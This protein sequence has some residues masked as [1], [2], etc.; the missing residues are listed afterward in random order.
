MVTVTPAP[1]ATAARR[2]TFRSRLEAQRADCLRQR[3]LALRDTVAS[4]PDLVAMARSS[5]LLRTVDEID[6]ALARLDAGTYGRCITCASDI[7]AERLEFRPFATACV[8]CQQ[9]VA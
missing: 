2:A 8:T 7:P 3:E 4:V 1:A 5:Q 6:D 9:Q